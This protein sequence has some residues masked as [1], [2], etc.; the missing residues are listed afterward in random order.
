M[1]TSGATHWS[2]RGSL[3]V[4]L[5]PTG[6]RNARPGVH[7]EDLGFEGVFFV[8]HVVMRAEHGSDCP[9]RGTV[10][11]RSRY[12]CAAAGPAFSASRSIASLEDSASPFDWVF[13]WWTTHDQET[14]DDLVARGARALKVDPWRTGRRARTFLDGACS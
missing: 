10:A 5:R 1:C 3:A 2:W 9:G 14:R 11:P 4:A 8:D 12:E 13:P 7:A 6:S